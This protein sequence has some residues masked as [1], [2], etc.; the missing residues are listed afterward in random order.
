MGGSSG[1]R[2]ETRED[3]PSERGEGGLQALDSSEELAGLDRF[4]RQAV[5]V[6][7]SDRVRAALDL[8]REPDALRDDYGRK[9][10]GQGRWPRGG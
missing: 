7:H 10:L 2:R 8:S 1:Y 6:L 9:P 3:P 5:E 4:H